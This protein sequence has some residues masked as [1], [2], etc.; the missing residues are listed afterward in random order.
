MNHDHDHDHHSH[1]HDEPHA[2]EGDALVI[3]DDAGNLLAQ[4]RVDALQALLIRK[5]ILSAGEVPQAIQA[6][7]SPGTH[8][9]A[10][11]RTRIARRCR[12]GQN[13]TVMYL[14]T[15]QRLRR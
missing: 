7:E 8:L 13:R 12:L 3:D 10:R 1:E 11:A 14:R 15:A 2:H 4:Q 5:G 6:L 9:G